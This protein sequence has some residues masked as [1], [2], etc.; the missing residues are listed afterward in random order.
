MTYAL[1]AC[2]PPFE[3]VTPASEVDV[4]A[5]VFALLAVEICDLPSPTDSHT[6]YAIARGVT[7]DPKNPENWEWDEFELSKQ[8]EDDE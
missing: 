3:D 7:T 1:E 5:S 8:D 2:L 4:P 6:T